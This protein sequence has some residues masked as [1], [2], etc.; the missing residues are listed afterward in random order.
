LYYIIINVKSK[1]ASV[2]AIRILLANIFLEFSFIVT[3]FILFLITGSFEFLDFSKENKN[4]YLAV[5][6]PIISFFFFIYAL[7]E[8]KRAPFDHAESE[9]ELVAGH[10]V[11]FSGRSLLFFYFSEYVHLYFCIFLFFVFVGGS[12]Q[13]LIFHNLFY[14]FDFYF[15]NQKILILHNKTILTSIYAIS[16]EDI[17]NDK[18]AADA[19]DY[20]SD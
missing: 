19:L 9:S 10:L 6:M 20:I 11:E 5:N 18:I 2:G 13:P 7:Y 17:L 15:F 16:N 14:N 3:F 4:G 1:Y 8:S 12:D